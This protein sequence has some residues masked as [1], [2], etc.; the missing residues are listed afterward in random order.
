[1]ESNNILFAQDPISEGGETVRD[2]ATNTILSESLLGII[3]FVSIIALLILLIISVLYILVPWVIQ[4]HEIQKKESELDADLR[5][6][7]LEA[8]LEVNR[9]LSESFKKLSSAQTSQT[10]ILRRMDNQISGISCANK[11]PQNG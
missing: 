2:I 4:K 8:D 9:Q 11:I 5:R 10:E 6:T 3:I 7:K 1:M